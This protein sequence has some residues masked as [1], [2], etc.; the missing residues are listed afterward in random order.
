MS[1]GRVEVNSGEGPSEI[2]MKVLREDYWPVLLWAQKKREWE[3]ADKEAAVIAAEKL[4]KPKKPR[5]ET[6]EQRMRR[7]D[8]IDRASCAEYVLKGMENSQKYGCFDP[9][10]HRLDECEREWIPH[11]KQPRTVERKTVGHV[12]PLQRSK[13]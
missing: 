2:G 1:A 11:F 12:E 4:A 13:N 6:I 5:K 9:P 10:T 3:A 7:Q 8:K